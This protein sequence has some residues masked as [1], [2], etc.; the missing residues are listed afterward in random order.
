LASPK[1]CMSGRCFSWAFAS[2]MHPQSIFRSSCF[3]ASAARQ[4]LVSIFSNCWHSQG[5]FV[6]AGNQGSDVYIYICPYLYLYWYLFIEEFEI[7]VFRVWGCG[8]DRLSPDI[9]A[10][11]YTNLLSSDISACGALFGATRYMLT[12]M[13][14]DNLWLIYV[15]LYIKW[16]WMTMDDWYDMIWMLPCEQNVLKWMIWMY[17]I[18]YGWFGW[19]GQ[20]FRWLSPVVTLGVSR[21][22]LK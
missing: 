17:M 9:Y 7:P 10:D 20:W 16:L 19:H 18:W 2:L 15:N 8:L 13:T 11:G 5:N 3:A 14:M 12:W 1:G 4:L 6:R 22:I 21:N